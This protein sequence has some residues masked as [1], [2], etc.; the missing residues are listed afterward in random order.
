M[1]IKKEHN[2][3]TVFV[4]S[5]VL[6]GINAFIEIALGVLLLF[7]GEVIHIV[8]FLVQGELIEDPT[9][10]FATHAANF[11]PYLA[12]NTGLFASFYLLSHGLIKGFLVVGLLRDK[13]WAYPASIVF[14]VLFI[15]YQILRFTYTHSPFLVVLTIFDMVVIWLVWHEY[16]YLKTKQTENIA[17]Q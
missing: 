12:T 6:K 15:A 17:V 2:I 9:D 10:F 11:L 4:W 16:R 1:D 14:L 3:H 8:S 13:L 5:V 7:T